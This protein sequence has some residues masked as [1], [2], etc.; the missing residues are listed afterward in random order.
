VTT[1]VVV[2]RDDLTDQA[3]YRLDQFVMR[4]GRLLVLASGVDI[5]MSRMQ[6][7]DR[8]VKMGPLLRDYG[9]EVKNSLVVDAQAPMVSF[10]VGFFIP[11]SVRYP[12]FPQVVS[13]GL[14]KQSPITSEMQSLTLPWV[15]PL[16]PVPVDT[17]AGG[18]VEREV[19]ARSSD[20]S[21]ARTA[22]YDLNPQ[23]RL[24][25][26][27]EGSEPLPLAMALVGRFPSHW[28]GG[29]PIPGD[30]LGTAP[31]GPEVS[32]QTQMVVVGT[33]HIAD[34][35]FLGQFPA[36]AVFLANAVDW[37]T[38]GDDLIAIRSRGAVSRPLKEIADNKRTAYKMLAMIPVPIL[39]VFFGLVRARVRRSRR[40]AV[41]ARL[42][43]GMS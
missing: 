14:S 2:D 28:R 6:A 38:L 43:G 27:P 11:L 33:P 21:Y 34:D 4:G 36:N 41:A 1:L 16:A 35:R 13:E 32:L 25:P 22:P 42:R 20:R 37:M 17:A 3:L 26:P 5:E 12:W 7:R 29:A 39:V 23:S 10:D 9:V 15:S 24:A 31:R 19:L 40:L 30:S 18:E 8:G